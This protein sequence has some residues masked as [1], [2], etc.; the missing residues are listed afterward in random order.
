[1]GDLV[2]VDAV[3]LGLAA[4]DEF[5]L[6]GVTHGKKGIFKISD[7]TKQLQMTGHTKEDFPTTATSVEIGDRV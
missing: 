6:Q 4:V 1:M 2:G 5:P 7:R 3:V